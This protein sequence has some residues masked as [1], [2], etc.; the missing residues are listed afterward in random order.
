MFKHALFRACCFVGLLGLRLY[1]KPAT[2]KRII[3]K[4]REND[5]NLRK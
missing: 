1:L 3:Q 2:F 4:K 5:G